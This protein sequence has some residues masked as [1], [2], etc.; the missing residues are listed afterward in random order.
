[1]G[2]L[3]EKILFIRMHKHFGETEFFNQWQRAYIGKGAA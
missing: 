2:K 1:M 3:F